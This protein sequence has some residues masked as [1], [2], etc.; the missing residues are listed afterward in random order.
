MHSLARLSRGWPTDL[1]AFGMICCVAAGSAAAEEVGQVQCV[2]RPNTTAAPPSGAPQLRDR[3][4]TNIDR[5]SSAND[6]LVKPACPEG[7]IPVGLEAASKVRFPK[8]NPLLRSQGGTEPRSAAP[9]QKFLRFEDV[10]TK[11]QGSA[12]EKGP[13]RT[14]DGAEECPNPYSGTCYYYAAVAA[15]GATNGAGMTISVNKPKYFNPDA[16]GHTLDEIAI[17]GGTGDGNIV[18][19][20]WL[21]STDQNGDADPHLFVFHWKNGNEGGYNGF[22]WQQYSNKY[23]PGQNVAA[24]VGYEVY[25]GYVLF[26]E[27][28]WA[29]FDGQWLGYFPGTLWENTFNKVTLVQ[30]FGEVA[31]TKAGPPQIQMG[32]G[33]LPPSLAAARMFTIC[34]VDAK[35]WT[36]STGKRQILRRPTRAKFYEIQQLSPGNALY[37]G[38]GNAAVTSQ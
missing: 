22:G 6:N 30:W 8:G 19:L 23:Y 28:W 12:V 21:V 20:G 11:K 5:N 29:W 15:S 37:G 25:V 14:Q 7:Q 13:A 10:Y 33:V 38:P 27:N 34:Q 9:D 35:P 3:T 24:L 16:Q 17:Q 26:R 32:S 2:P 31:T 36:C 4:R 18:E 1:F